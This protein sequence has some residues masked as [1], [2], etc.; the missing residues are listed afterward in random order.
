MAH[1]K[2]RGVTFHALC[3]LRLT[4][5]FLLNYHSFTDLG[6]THETPNYIPSQILALL[7]NTKLSK[8]SC[9]NLVS[10]L[11]CNKYDH[12]LTGLLTE[13]TPTYAN[14]LLHSNII[15]HKY[16]PSSNYQVKKHT[17]L[18]NIGIQTE[19]N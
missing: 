17:F 5:L 4:S 16:H 14:N 18:S 12:V 9:H 6:I 8:I 10:R 2:A 19:L 15:R 3:L 1:I 11:Q 13:K 7:M